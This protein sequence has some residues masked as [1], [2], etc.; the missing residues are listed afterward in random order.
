MN[1]FSCHVLNFFNPLM[2]FIKVWWLKLFRSHYS[3]AP[4][5]APSGDGI[6]PATRPANPLS[7]H[8]TGG[9]LHHKCGG[10][11]PR[12]P[13]PRTRLTVSLD[14]GDPDESAKVTKG[15]F[16]PII[17]RGLRE[18]ISRCFCSAHSGFWIKVFLEEPVSWE[19]FAFFF[20]F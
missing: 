6:L 7:S 13:R 18:M 14:E 19:S 12:E 4:L 3:T 15:T 17:D 2:Y 5:A 10:S 8:S 11:W 16:N 9:R 1:H 20:F